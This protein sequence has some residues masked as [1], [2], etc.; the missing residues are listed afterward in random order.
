MCA[1]KR[2]IECVRQ[3]VSGAVIMHIDLCLYS[4][5]IVQYTYIYILCF[6]FIHGSNFISLCFRFITL[7]PKTKE[8]KIS[9][10][11]E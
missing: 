10:K 8:N 3:V 4:T 5:S 7:H 11:V 6:T 2:D 9:T 1:T